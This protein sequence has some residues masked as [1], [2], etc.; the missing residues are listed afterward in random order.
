M[1]HPIQT[2]RIGPYKTLVFESP[3]DNTDIIANPT[4]I[5]QNPDESE[6]DFHSRVRAEREALEEE[7]IKRYVIS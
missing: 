5:Q 7:A 3:N 1:N 2:P 6:E 4:G